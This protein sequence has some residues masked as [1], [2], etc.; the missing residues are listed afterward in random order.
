MLRI[1]ITC[2]AI[3]IAATEPA[4]TPVTGR[5]LGKREGHRLQKIRNRQSA[6]ATQMT[7]SEITS[8]SGINDVSILGRASADNSKVQSK[9]EKHRQ[10]LKR[11]K[12]NEQKI[13]KKKEEKHSNVSTSA[14]KPSKSGNNGTAP[15]KTARPTTRSRVEGKSNKKPKQK[16]GKPKQEGGKSG[17]HVRVSN[18]Q[19]HI[20]H[21]QVQ[22]L[23][24]EY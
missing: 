24:S 3:C 8:T 2:F 1:I 19:A 9:K 6:S 5:E 21:G 10:K 18:T 12:E 13:K 20:Q 7:S 23:Y 17:K 14:S 22:W 11:K 16:P 4:I 15:F